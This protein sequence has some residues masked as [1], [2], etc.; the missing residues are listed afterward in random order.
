MKRYFQWAQEISHL[1]EEQ[2]EQLYQ[3]YLNGE[4]T[5]DLIAEYKLPDTVRSV[6]KVLPP[7]V[8]ADLT[9]PYCELP[10]WMHRPSRGTPVSLRSA[11]KCVNC[12]HQYFTAGAGSRRSVCGCDACVRLRKQQLADQ[13][14][15]DRSDL[16]ARYGTPS[17]PVPFASLGFQQKV[18]L[19][20]LLDDG[21]Q[22]AG[23]RIAALDAEIRGEKLTSTD[24]FSEEL[25]KGLHE[26]GAL[27]VD[28]ASDIR[29]FNRADEF[30]IGTYSAVYWRANVALDE[31]VRCTRDMLYL[32]LYEELSGP[33]LPVWKRELYALI[34]RLAREE[35]IQYVHLQAN[36]VGMA[37]TAE[38]RA[39]SVIGTLLQNFSVSQI[40]YFARVAVKS[41]AHFYATGNSKGRTHASNT[42]PRNMQSTAQ[43]ALAENWRKDSYRDTRV[44]QPAMTRL[45]YDVVLKDSGAGFAKSPGLFWRDEFVPRFLTGSPVAAPQVDYPQLFCRECDS[46]NVDASMDK[47]TLQMQCYDC[48]TVSK[49]RAYEELP[50]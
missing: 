4:K 49:F 35:S 31:G 40:Y 7:I 36:M 42:I 23:E 27:Q 39:D 13:A 24:A 9:C 29:A 12:E 25:V 26:A 46:S 16:A 32:A 50:D 38:A 15:R 8:S 28:T 41:A 44:P 17:P 6:L 20:A 30:S 19:L 33:V 5:A 22:G 3:R 47:L 11:Y 37:F 1:S 21:G 45:L 48:A 43:L 10:M 14:E 34:F 18:A 2:V